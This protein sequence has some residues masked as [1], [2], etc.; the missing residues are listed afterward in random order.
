MMNGIVTKTIKENNHS[1]V[2]TIRLF[3]S[4]QF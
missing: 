1:H 3:K 4:M 2:V